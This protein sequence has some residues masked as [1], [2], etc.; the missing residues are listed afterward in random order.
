HEP[1]LAVSC[2]LLIGLIMGCIIVDEVG[3]MLMVDDAATSI[4]ELLLCT[5]QLLNS[6]GPLLA[7][8]CCLHALLKVGLLLL[9]DNA[10]RWTE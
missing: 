5:L 1:L 4:A 8:C 9:L 3:L 6:Y 7:S 10:V 2:E